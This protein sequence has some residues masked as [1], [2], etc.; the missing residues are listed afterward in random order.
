MTE[1]KFPMG[2]ETGGETETPQTPRE[3][4][5]AYLQ[6]ALVLYADNPAP[7]RRR[8]DDPKKL[9]AIPPNDPRGELRIGRY[10]YKDKHYLLVTMLNKS[11]QIDLDTNTGAYNFWDPT[12]GLTPE[13]REMADED[14]KKVVV[15]LTG[16]LPAQEQHRLVQ[17]LTNW[18]ESLEG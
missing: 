18:R 8:D 11:Y 13:C 15:E 6:E 2:P 17:I 5:L 1:L 12:S 4:A 14:Y 7:D 16:G 3:Q 9:F 10:R